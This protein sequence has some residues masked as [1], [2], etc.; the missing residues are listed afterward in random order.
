M[1]SK[2]IKRK[3]YDRKAYVRYDGVKVAA[4]HVPAGW[5]KDVGKPGKSKS[6]IPKQSLLK[7]P[8]K[9]HLTDTSEMRHKAI[10]QSVKKHGSLKTL[11]KINALRTLQK[12]NEKNYK[13]LSKD[14]AYAQKIHA[15]M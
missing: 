3:A 9:Y 7:I 11:Q 13:K 8:L 14:L 5:I 15:H 1:S 4:S 2:V 12:S 10:R 6:T